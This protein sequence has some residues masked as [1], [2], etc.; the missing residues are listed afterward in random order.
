MFNYVFQAP[1]GRA[2]E[3]NMVGVSGDRMDDFIHYIWDTDDDYKTTSNGT[4]LN[5]YSMCNAKDSEDKPLYEVPEV[6]KEIGRDNLTRVIKSSQGLDVSEIAEMGFVGHSDEQIM[7][8]FGMEAYTNPE[9]IQN[10]LTYFSKYGLLKNSFFNDFKYVNLSA[11]KTFHLLEPISTN[12][13]PMPN[14]IALQRANIY[15]YQT[16]FYQLATAQAY[17]PDSYGASQMLSVANLSDQAIVFTTHP[18]QLESTKTVGATPGYWAGFGRAPHAVQ[19]E[20]IMIQ[21][22]QIPEKSGF[23]ELYDVPQFTHTYLP[24][25]YFDEVII[26]GRYAF[27]RVGNAYISLTGASNLRYNE[28]H[29]YSAIALESGL[30]DY[31]DKRFDLIQEGN[32]QYWIYELSDA[33]QEGF[34]D[35][36]ARIKANSVTYDGESEISYLSGGRNYGLTYNGDF[37]IEGVV[38]NLQYDR[39]DCEYAQ[40]AR[41]QKSYTYS[42]GGHSLTINYETGERVIG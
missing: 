18:A 23:L 10:T 39:Y 3:S 21:L 8:Q 30:Q 2:Y 27:A 12:L 40:G 14:G 37:T 17:H 28:F 13:N 6:I 36:M 20:N 22:Y 4:F 24:E 15:T 9:V 29:D 19:D 11:L 7:M 25:A 5:F 38:Q 35:F 33:T 41:E 31:P 42:F 32:N 34:T 26:D 1:T 16:R